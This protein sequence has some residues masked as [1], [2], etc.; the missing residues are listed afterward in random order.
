MRHE[1]RTEPLPEPARRRAALLSRGCFALL[2]L[3]YGLIVLGSTVRAHGAGLACPDWPLCFGELVPRFDFRV[4]FEW[5]HR[6]VAGT[7]SILFALLAV[8]IL[9]SPSLRR[10]A[11]RPLL[12]AAALL[13]IQ[14]VLG[15]LTVLHLLASWTVTAHLLTGNAFALVLLWTGLALRDHARPRPPP[16]AVPGSLRALLVAGAALLLLQLFLGGLVSSRYAGLACPDW[17]ACEGGVFFPT[18]EGPIGLQVL[19]RTN[20]Y[21]LAAVLA[22]LAVGARRLPLLAGPTRLAALLVLLQIAVGVAN[23][24]LRI[25]VE[26]TA[27]HSALAAALVLVLTLCVRLA[28]RGAPEDEDLPLARPSLRASG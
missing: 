16:A 19:H 3:S 23:V 14:V 24:G 5:G 9:R 12:V 2:A 25:P 8:A 21:A 20:G 4:A 27:L 1:S 10:V 28:F 13:A 18:L 26:I 22:A 11:G 15:G 6:L 7:V 17:P